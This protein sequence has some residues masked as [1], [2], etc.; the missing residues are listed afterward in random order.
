MGEVYRARDP[1][2]ERDVAI[3]ILPASFALDADRLKRFEREARILASLDHR[4]IAAIYGVEE[5]EGRTALI[6][7][8]VEGQTLAERIER[9][10]IE[11][12][13]ALS[14]ARQIADA[15]ESAHEQGIIHRD[16][17]P[18]NIKVRSD[19]TV[20]VLDFGLAK[21]GSPGAGE[22][23]D[24]P[25]ITAVATR[26]GT[27]MG[28]A[29]YMSPEQ[30]RGR[31]VDRRTDIWAFGCILFEMFAGRRAFE[32][33][34]TNETLSKVLQ[35]EPD[36]QGLP[37]ETPRPIR[38]LVARC[39][40]KDPRQRL[41]DIGDAR[42]TIE[43]TLS[44]PPGEPAPATPRRRFFASPVVLAGIALASAAVTY[45][46]TRLGSRGTE[47]TS[48]AEFDHIVRFVAS[49]AHEFSPAIS[50]DGKWVAYL[51]NARGP[52]DIWLKSVASGDA[53]NL[54]AAF[55][56]TFN[57]ELQTQDSIGGI[58][59]SPDGTQMAFVGGPPGVASIRM[60]TY[61]IP[62]PLGGSPRR[63]L[64]GRQGMRWSPDGKYLTYIEPGGSRGDSLLI[65]DADGQN[66]R[67]LVKREGARHIHW[68]RW[69]ADGRHVYFNY[70]FQNGNSE[71][72]EIFRVAVAGGAPQ[73]VVR[74]SRRA[75]FPLPSPDGRG[76]FFAGNPN[77]V[78]TNLWWQD[79]ATDRQ[80]R[81]TFGIGE[82]GPSA[83]SADGRRLVAMVSDLRETLQ[84]V[85]VT[86]G[87]VAVLEPLTGGDTGD[88]DPC[89]SPDGTRLVFSSTRTGQRTIW[90]VKGDLSNPIALTDG[91]G[92]DERPE[93]SPDGQQ[94][95]FV[96][97][98]GGRRGIWVVSADGGGL[99][100]LAPVAVLTSISWSSDGK[101]LAYAVG[102]G[103]MPQIETID[104]SSGKVTRLPTE[105][106]ASS[107]AWSPTEDVIAYLETTDK[108][109]Y[110]RFMTGDGR[111]VSR[112]SSD[113][114][115]LNNGFVRWSSDGKRL[116]G[117]GIPGNQA[118]YIWIIDPS[119]VV[120]SRK[121]IDL[122][123]DVY[124]RGGSW[125]R[126]GSSFVV[127]LS[128]TT[129]DIILAERLR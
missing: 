76:L 56:S 50:P 15:V 85:A 4:H 84:R 72:T 110:L 74:S 73:S 90:S 81:V 88:I 65:A 5:S 11:Q 30:A 47:Q 109:G 35:R 64:E 18:A 96:S 124:P 46:L 2:L 22:T 24:A 38:E 28:T 82:Y 19:G 63:L 126:D 17:K 125:S 104:V 75:V 66:P 114:T 116:A 27:V 111:P 94:V 108:G 69:S 7:E 6:L 1:R 55:A 92:F 23:E 13:D 16:L 44:K 62:V 128:R 129:G 33:D 45:G 87:R 89:W 36:W 70:G 101:R 8:L 71:Q 59:L 112:G 61:V 120:P 119:G 43:E 40:Q 118:G 103:A 95:A 102:G 68:P 51:S 80:Q 9:G 37:P 34:S 97:D 107:P 106:A 91:R 54:T 31:L 117:V 25:T 115:R 79:L 83:I 100:L 98:R 21:S 52:T 29:A 32:A 26:E 57:L 78:E 12:Q 99:R 60:S 53:K 86:S 58:E 3:K 113:S 77:G 105:A 10:P 93:Y 48:P 41:R 39:L 67:Q 122:P 14:I 20:K 121:L 123:P 127:G 42:I 49:P